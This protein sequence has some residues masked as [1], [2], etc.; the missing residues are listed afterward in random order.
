MAIVMLRHRL[1]QVGA[2]R[3]DLIE[4][5]LVQLEDIHANIVKLRKLEILSESLTSKGSKPKF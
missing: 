1:P 5:W 4:N 2:Q 3:A